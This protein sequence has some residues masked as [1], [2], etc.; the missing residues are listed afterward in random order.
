MK[1][2]VRLSLTDPMTNSTKVIE[3]FNISE[4]ELSKLWEV[5]ISNSQGACTSNLGRE[6]ENYPKYWVSSGYVITSN[7][8]YN[9]TQWESKS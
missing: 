2:N 7:L 3:K 9:W 1:F 8:L 6:P 5:N 4:R